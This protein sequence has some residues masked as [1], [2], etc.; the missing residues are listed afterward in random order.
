[1]HKLIAMVIATYIVLGFRTAESQTT[2]ELLNF[3]IVSDIQT[4]GQPNLTNIQNQ[5]GFISVKPDLVLTNLYQVR[6]APELDF[7]SRNRPNGAPPLPKALALTLHSADV[8]RYTNMCAQ[9]RCRRLLVTLGEYPLYECRIG[10]FVAPKWWTQFT[11]HLPPEKIDDTER[12]LKQ[13]VR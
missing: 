2:N 9:A 6:R 4:P 8:P 12:Q 10:D 7:S 5:A 3:Y 11:L 13:L 1:M